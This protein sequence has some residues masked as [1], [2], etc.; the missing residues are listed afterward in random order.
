MSKFLN[1]LKNPV[2]G[3]FLVNIPHYGINFF[4]QLSCATS[5]RFLGPGQ[6]L[7]KINDTI[8]RKCLHEMMKGQKDRHT[9]PI[10]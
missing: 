4:F 2:F 7:E 10:S 3:P 9:D 6:N 8:L 5:Y 1:K